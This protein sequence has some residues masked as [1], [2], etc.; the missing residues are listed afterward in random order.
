MDLHMPLLLAHVVAGG[1][2]LLLGPV[3]A[4]AAAR[5]PAYATR[6]ITAYQG[7]VTVV[8]VTALGLVALAPA[9]FWW[10]IPIAVGTQA[11]I[12]VARR[13]GADPAR[14]TR[15]LG[16]SYVSLVT[17]LLVVSWGN[18][19]AWIVPTVLGIG[20]VESAAARVQRRRYTDAR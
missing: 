10:L 20:L 3:A 6:L 15:L 19:L 1:L 8:C 17:A 2:G 11:A 16:G 14:R 5:R 4:L 12:I 18:P 9:T 7:A 13:S